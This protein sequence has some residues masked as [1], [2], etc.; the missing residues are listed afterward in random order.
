M[1]FKLARKFAHTKVTFIG[2]GNM[3]LQMALNLQKGGYHVTGFDLN[4][5]F[6]ESFKKQ[7]GETSS[8][9]G[10]SIK[11][12]DCV[13]TMLP[14][15]QATESVWSTAFITAR[16]DTVFIDTSTISPVDAKKISQVA[17]DKDFI[18][19]IS[20]VSGGVIGAKNA[21]LSFMLGCNK[22]HFEKAKTLLQPMGKNFY[23][24]GDYSAGQIVKI[25]NNLCLAISMVGLS[26]SLALGVKLGA[27]PKILSSVMTTS[28][29]KCWSLESY[30]PIPGVLPN[31][32]SSRNYDNGYNNELLQKDLQFADDCAKNADLDIEFG[33]K[34]LDYYT[35]LNNL[36]LKKKDIGIIYKYI[37]DN[38]KSSL[39]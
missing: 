39:F 3:G 23:H 11:E 9:M 32:P 34:A 22:E 1:F 31:V 2:L 14:N 27:D 37:L 19:V 35:R 20:P 4:N 36:G 15:F 33:R 13:I 10:Q 5:D 16:K 28:T 12:S 25:C 38:K 29:A 21:T 18:P 6:V 24:C 17:L 8:D 26:E 7:G 30:N